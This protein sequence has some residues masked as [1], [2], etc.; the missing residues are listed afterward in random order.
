MITQIPKRAF[1]PG[2]TRKPKNGE[3]PSP[4]LSQPAR[5]KRCS[6]GKALT[7]NRRAFSFPQLR[8]ISRRTGPRDSRVSAATPR[9]LAVGRTPSGG[10]S[11]ARSRPARLSSPFPK[12]EAAISSRAV[13]PRA[14]VPQVCP[15]RTGSKS[16]SSP[17]FPARAPQRTQMRADRN[18]RA[19]IPISGKER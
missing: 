17:P 1:P 13:I 2:L 10:R 15:C 8:A 14:I 6:A 7:V 11:T 19:P 5:R 4:S 12:T 16:P 9:K 18:G 3:D